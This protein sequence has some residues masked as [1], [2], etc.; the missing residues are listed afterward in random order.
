MLFRANA[1]APP[2]LL[3][4]SCPLMAILVS[5][6]IFQHPNELSRQIIFNLKQVVRLLYVGLHSG[7]VKSL[8]RSFVTR[9][10]E[11]NYT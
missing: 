9:K 1:S 5:L 11:Q 8:A 6:T 4:L 7:A 10:I 3:V 2:T